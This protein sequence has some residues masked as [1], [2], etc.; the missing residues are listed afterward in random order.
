[1]KKTDCKKVLINNMAF[2]GKYLKRNVGGFWAFFIGWYVEGL[3]CFILPV[4]LGILADEMMY[5]QNIKDFT[6]IACCIVLITVFWCVLYFCVYMFF[7]DNY[8]KYA[9]DIKKDLFSKLGKMALRSFDQ[10]ANGDIINMIINYS[11][12]CIFI[13]NR[14]IIYAVRAISLIVLYSFYIFSLNAKIGVWIVALVSLSSY[15][16]I[17][18]TAKISKYSDNE[19]AVNSEFQ[20]WIFD[21]LRG[22]VDMKFLQSEKTAEDKY[23]AYEENLIDLQNKKKKFK[24]HMQMISETSNFLL[25]LIVFIIAANAVAEKTITIGAFLVIY[26]FYKEIKECIL[27]MNGYFSDWFDRLSSVNYIQKFLSEE[28]ETSQ[29]ADAVFQEGAI[30]FCGASFGYKDEK[31]IL[32]NV[33]ISVPSGKITAIV[34]ESGIGKTILVNLIMRFYELDSGKICIDGFDIGACSL[35]SLR[36]QIGYV[37]QNNYFFE[38]TI[39]ENLLLGNENADKKEIERA[40]LLVGIYDEIM[41]KPEGFRT[42]LGENGEGLS[43]GQKQ[44]LSIARILL[45]NPQIIIFDEPTSALDGEN[46]KIFFDTV[47]KLDGHTVIII[48]HRYYT[49]RECDYILLLK[50]NNI[51]IAA[52]EKLLESQYIK[53]LFGNYSARSAHLLRRP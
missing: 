23:I 29:G 33:N 49:L 50:D 31:Q 17:R 22:I 2:L 44:R 12:E 19:K 6:T 25:E 13:I 48:S 40:C 46:E 1:M 30:S 42:M 27:L 47:K 38:G 28:E 34:G 15:I 37:Q 41:E 24:Y 36:R 5:H 39:Y 52:R 45:R 18:T 16:S 9:F 20:G 26:S 8:S 51:Q 21:I 32:K 4:F 10:I 43:G 11:D 53:K 14:N 7:N 3:L 35:K